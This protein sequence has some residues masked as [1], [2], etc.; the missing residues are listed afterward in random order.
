MS[1]HWKIRQWS[2]QAPTMGVL[3]LQHR[4]MDQGLKRVGQ[5]CLEQ[6]TRTMFGVL[7]AR[8]PGTQ[9]ID[10]GNSMENLKL[11]AKNGV[12]RVDN[13]QAHFT[14]SQCNESL[15]QERTKSGGGKQNELNKEVE[16]LKN[17]LETLE[18]PMGA[19]SLAKSG[20]YSLSHVFNASDKS[21]PNSWV[22]DSGTTDHM[23]HSTQ[24][25]ST[26][27]PCPSNKKIATADGS[28]TTVAG[29]KEVHL[30][31]SIVLKI[32]LHIPKLS[33]NLVSIHRLTKDLNCHVIFHPFD[34]V[35]QDQVSGKTIGH[36][37]EKDG[38]YHRELPFDQNRPRTGHPYHSSPKFH[39]PKETR[40]GSNIIVL[41]IH[42]SVLLRLC[43]LYCSK[44]LM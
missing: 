30:D 4:S 17:M 32:V 27:S 25:F 31:N 22:I 40:S 3:K 28:L 23:T 35:F 24:K 44:G 13:S 6:P 7:T 26:Y 2:Q 42:H 5:I 38:L 12:S 18:K 14:N 21:F 8:S 33:T 11:Q 16:K 36:A 10:V 43:F 41:D 15:P 34:Y 29:Q 39:P 9:R 37:R 1:N 20:K 19:C